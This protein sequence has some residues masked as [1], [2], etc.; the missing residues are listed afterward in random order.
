MANQIYDISLVANGIPGQTILSIRAFKGITDLT[1]NFNFIPS[2]NEVIKLKVVFDTEIPLL[3]E[4]ADIPES[5]QYTLIPSSTDFIISKYIQITVYF[6]NF[7]SY[8]Y[9]IPVE[10][11]QPSYYNNFQGLKIKTAQFVDTDDNGDVFLTLQALDKSLYNFVLRSNQILPATQSTVDVPLLAALSANNIDVNPI[12][13][14][15]DD[16]IEVIEQQ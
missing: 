5:I 2:T 10:V 3:F 11:A 12:A 1:F 16:N 6:D 9:V 15:F 8:S 7:A 14:N 13:T 4:R